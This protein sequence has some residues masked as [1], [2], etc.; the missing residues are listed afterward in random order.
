MTDHYIL[1]GQTPAPISYDPY[2]P[3][4]VAAALMADA[5]RAMQWPSARET[6][7]RPTPRLRL[8]GGVAICGYHAAIRNLR[9]NPDRDLGPNGRNNGK[10]RSKTA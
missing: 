1:A 8:V 2:P 6:V 7:A 5:T 10:R 3:E 4:G 9:E